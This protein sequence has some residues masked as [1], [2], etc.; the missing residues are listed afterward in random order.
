MMRK[1]NTTQQSPI[2]NIPPELL[3]DIFVLCLPLLPEH[4]QPRRDAAPLSISQT[5]RHWREVSHSTPRLWT[6]S[7]NLLVD[8]H[9]SVLKGTNTTVTR[10]AQTTPRAPY[11]Q[12]L[13]SALLTS[14]QQSNNP[15]QANPVPATNSLR[16]LLL[17]IAHKTRSIAFSVHPSHANALHGLWDSK[18]SSIWT[19]LVDFRLNLDVYPPTATLNMSGLERWIDLR[20]CPNL[21][22][23]WINSSTTTLINSPRVS[24]PWKQL[25][26]LRIREQNLSWWN[27]APHF[28]GQPTVIEDLVLIIGNGP[29][30]ATD[31]TTIKMSRLKNLRIHSTLLDP[32]PN[33]SNL[34]A[35]DLRSLILNRSPVAGD[36]ASDQFTSSCI[37]GDL[38]RTD[39]AISLPNAL[40]QFQTRSCFSLERLTLIALD[41]SPARMILALASLPTLR[42]LELRNTG[43]LDETFLSDL[44]WG[45]SAGSTNVLPVLEKLIMTDRTVAAPSV[46]GRGSAIVSTAHLEGIML[47]MVES[48]WKIRNNPG[49]VEEPVTRLKFVQ[50]EI[51][52]TRKGSWREGRIG[53]DVHKRMRTLIYEGLDLRYTRGSLVG[54]T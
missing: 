49:S 31:P 8:F 21:R 19:A 34:V 46:F 4:R 39:T 6:I 26:S 33:I 45:P 42:M 29:F 51:G 9:V 11:S 10:P 48:R 44:R 38:P 54:R 2:F 47:D 30:Y 24:L 43:C 36:L 35:P 25:T 7:G 22:S 20:P 27:L 32:T 40:I 23:V 53:D 37:P 12:W 5:C 17:P 1:R 50:V 41:L 13:P 3:A 14:V 28:M 18:S 16:Q 15:N 52:H